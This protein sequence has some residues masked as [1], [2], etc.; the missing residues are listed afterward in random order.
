MAMGKPVIC[1]KL[2]GIIQ[3]FGEGNG[4]LFVESSE[5]VL[6]TAYTIATNGII[7]NHGN[8]AR[9]YVQNLDWDTITDNFEQTINGAY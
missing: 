7:K 6:K 2:P 8:S 3:E 5:M 4:V 1:T 9:M